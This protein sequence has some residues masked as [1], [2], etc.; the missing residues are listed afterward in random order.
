MLHVPQ[1]IK[2]VNGTGFPCRKNL[3]ILYTIFIRF[4]EIRTQT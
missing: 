1:A 4:I 3:V 2:M